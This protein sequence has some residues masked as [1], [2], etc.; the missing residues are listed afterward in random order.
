MMVSTSSISLLL[1]LATAAAV[2]AAE[3]TKTKNPMFVDWISQQASSKIKTAKY[4]DLETE[5]VCLMQTKL[6]NCRCLNS[7]ENAQDEELCQRAY[8]E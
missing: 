4:D 5:D 3:S 1:V 2:S 7:V 8:E 6:R